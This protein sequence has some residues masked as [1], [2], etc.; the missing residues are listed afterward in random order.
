MSTDCPRCGSALTTFALDGT[1][2]VTCPDCG[3]ADVEADHSGEPRLDESWAEAF[4]RFE[5]NR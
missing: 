5:T 2:A 3:F 4:D 1:E